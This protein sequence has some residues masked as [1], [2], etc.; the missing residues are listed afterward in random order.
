MLERTLR[1]P[2]FGRGARIALAALVAA[3]VALGPTSPAPAWIGAETGYQTHDWFVD[4]AARL[5]GSDA[6]WFDVDAA[7]EASDDPDI[8]T[9]HGAD[10]VYRDQ[11]IRGAAIQRIVDHYDAAADDY[12]AGRYTDASREIGLLSHYYTDILQPY[13]SHYDGIGKT[14]Q[15][16]E[17]EHMVMDQTRDASDRPDWGVTGHVP[18]T[19][20][21]VRSEAIAAAAYSRA[22]FGGL[23]A[24]IAASGTT[25]TPAIELITEP[26]MR[27]GVNDLADIIRSIKRGA[28]RAPLV[29]RLTAS[30]KWRYPA[31]NEDWQH[32][33][34][35]AYDAA[36]RPIEGLEVRVTL[37]SGTTDLRYT[38]AAGLAYW[39]GPPGASP[40]YV[41][42]NVTVRATTDGHSESATTWWMTTPV[43]ATGTAGFATT[44]DRPVPIAGQYVTVRS[45]LR[46]TGGRPVPNVAVTWTWE[47]PGPDVTTTGTTNAQGV[48][49][50]RQLITPG[51]TFDRVII[52]AKAQSG[53]QNRN[54]S[55]SFQRKA[56]DPVT[57][58]EGW[59][60]DIWGSRFRDDIVWLAEEGITSGCATQ[61]FCPDG[62][63]TRAQMAT[64][65]SRALHLAPTSRD[66]FRDD[67]G[68][69]HE[70][71]INRLAAS[72]ITVGC[73]ADRFCPTGLVTRAQMAT[74][75][76]RAF[77]L[78]PTSTDFFADD[79]GSTHEAA[80]N[81]LA[82]SG[83]TGGCGS[84]RYCP[85]GVVTR[86]QM[87][88]FL[89]RALTD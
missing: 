29:D 6:S 1:A 59:F 23:H 48:A 70:A 66:Y 30:V 60:V 63:V 5:V 46:D 8:A 24:L 13:H 47:Y 49:T 15:H 40:H 42:Q 79:E 65:L 82:A 67:E 88:A 26:L 28:G 20:A 22:R 80:I 73:A 12:A 14:S 89:R 35:Y 21:N 43:L 87:A 71:A 3:G 61:R 32:I 34:T 75:L 7:R 17:Y 11:G 10:H 33:Y 57:P 39:S 83:I 53:S 45:T 81:R 36:G 44:V 56:G 64:F 51:T 76:S 62:S 69:T 78:P 4:Q 55:S 72:G 50:S 54:S 25:F 38:D 2:R 9:E 85:S 41:R 68:L 16:S 18:T 37:P 19:I 27:R 86:G 31:R 84:G 58:Y 77:K 74:F 52:R